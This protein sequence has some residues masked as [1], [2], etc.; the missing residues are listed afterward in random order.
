MIP[1]VSV[2]LDVSLNPDPSQLPFTGTLQDLAN[3]LLAVVLVLIAVAGFA[4]AGAWALGIATGNMSWADR[5]K[6]GFVVAAIAAILAGAAAIFVNFF[7]H[8]GQH[9][10]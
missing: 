1:I 9:L 7:F 4:S 6:S 5:G 3:G 8:L 10:H 2:L